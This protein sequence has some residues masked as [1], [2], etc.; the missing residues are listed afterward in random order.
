ME[1]VQDEPAKENFEIAEEKPKSI[2]IFEEVHEK[3]V[4]L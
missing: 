2:K 1:Q 3:M 4:F